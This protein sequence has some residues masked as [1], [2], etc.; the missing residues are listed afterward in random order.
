MLFL[1]LALEL[2]NEKVCPP[3]AHSERQNAPPEAE[4]F[5]ALGALNPLRGRSGRDWPNPPEAGSF[6]R[7]T[8]ILRIP[9]LG[10]APPKWRD[11]SRSGEASTASTRNVTRWR[12][13]LVP[14]LPLGGCTC[15]RCPSLG[16]RHE[17]PS[18]CHV[19]VVAIPCPCPLPRGWG[20][21][22]KRAAKQKPQRTD[23]LT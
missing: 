23:N 20:K 16:T 6:V 17:A 10:C 1:C 19:H 22:S 12:Q 21:K 5:I 11:A 18:A 14:R 9:H 13:R 15:P 3:V 2:A 4:S 8:N 7:S